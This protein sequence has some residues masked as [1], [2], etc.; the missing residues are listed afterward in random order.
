MSVAWRCVLELDEQMQITSGQPEELRAAIRR[1]A[2]LRIYSE[3]YHDE[4]I[5]PGSTAH[6]L[7][8]ESM[9]MRVTYL[10]DDRWC[11]GVLSLRQPVQLP[12]RFGPRPSLSLFLYNE[13]GQQAIAR[14]FLDGVAASPTS[15]T[16]APADHSRMQK[17]R[18]LSRFDD[19]TNA[20]SSNFVYSF[21]RLR[22][23]VREDWRELLRHQADGRVV[24]GSIN[25]LVNEFRNGAEFKIGIRDLC[26]DLTS[27]G[28]TLSHEVFVQLGSCYLYTDQ[29]L[30]IAATHPIPRVRPALPMTYASRN[31][32]YSW[33]IV[34]SD[35]HAALLVYDPYSL[36]PRR[37]FGRFELRWFCR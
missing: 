8:Q 6:E 19:G 22:Y 29:Q 33:L 28:P 31:W 25:E 37:Q 12:D 30:F 5:E 3:F 13:D 9:D 16:S 11:A 18:E 32:D 35:G 36:Q 20:P 17:Y 26:A 4:H 2:D 23:L 10:I 21:E 14:P 27:S 15:G 34:R 1:G 24:S 7:V